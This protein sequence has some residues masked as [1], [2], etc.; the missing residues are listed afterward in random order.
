M[1]HSRQP[2]RI[3]IPNG[4]AGVTRPRCGAP[5]VPNADCRVTPIAAWARMDPG[6]GVTRERSANGAGRGRR[7]SSP[8]GTRPLAGRECHRGGARAGHGQVRQAWERGEGPLRG[9]RHKARRQVAGAIKDSRE[10]RREVTALAARLQLPEP[11][12]M[13]RAGA[14]L[15]G[16]VASMSPIAVDLLSGALR[17]LHARAWEVQADTAALDRPRGRSRR[18]ALGSLP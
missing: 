9:Y 3:M 17:P 10:S 5:R 18:H 15:D 14:D 12:V 4:C 6:E 16:L 8:R 1:P 11:G 2:L 13:E 7:W